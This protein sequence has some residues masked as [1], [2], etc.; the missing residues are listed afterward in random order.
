MLARWFVAMVFIALG[1]NLPSADGTLPTDTLR[2]AVQKLQGENVNLTAASR[3]WQSAPIPH[4][5]NQ[6]DFFN[7]VIQVDTTLEPLHLLKF[8]HDTEERFGRVR[9]IKNE[10]RVLDLDLISYKEKIINDRNFQVPHPRMGERA[11]V[12]MPLREI[13]A[14]WRHPVSRETIDEM[15]KLLP[16]G[17]IL[18]PIGEKIA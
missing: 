7:A 10:P 11:F 1:A 9:L 15:I 12:L 5:K 2:L 14:D 8:L 17:Q 18:Q 13:C 4:N 6:P 3:I 16:P